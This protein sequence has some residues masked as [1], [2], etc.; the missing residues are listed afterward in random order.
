MGPD[1]ADF[2]H[3]RPLAWG[4]G[5]VSNFPQFDAG[6]LTSERAIRLLHF[7]ARFFGSLWLTFF[8]L[9]SGCVSTGGQAQKHLA[10]SIAP[11]VAFEIAGSVEWDPVF[12]DDREGAGFAFRSSLE[13][14][15]NQRATLKPL[16]DSVDSLSPL[17]D[18]LSEDAQSEFAVDVTPVEIDD[19]NVI[20][21]VQLVRQR[22]N[23]SREI[24]SEPRVVA[25]YGQASEIRELKP[26]PGSQFARL[27]IFVLP[28]QPL[29]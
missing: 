26:Q 10:K 24:L 29:R 21:L 22:A 12:A 23:G 7:V 4:F 5:F 6:W 2:G 18:T 17:D 11:R 19:T 16:P 27:Q 20:L 13:L 1:S 9:A 3:C 15:R 14:A 25:P 8:V 28:Q